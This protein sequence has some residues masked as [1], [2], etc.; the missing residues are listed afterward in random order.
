M[1]IFNNITDGGGDLKKALDGKINLDGSNAD[2]SN[3][4]ATAK[5]NIANTGIPD[6][7]QEQSIT[8][9]WTA[10]ENGLIFAYNKALHNAVAQ[11]L[12]NGV[13]VGYTSGGETVQDPTSMYAIVKKGDIITFTNM[14]RVVFY[15]FI[16]NI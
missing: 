8:S 10:T 5:T 12:V 7:T 6:Y 2:F 4:S 15:P 1:A 11:L 14:S 16:N 9:G 3:L 13:R